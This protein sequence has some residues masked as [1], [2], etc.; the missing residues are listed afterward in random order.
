MVSIIPRS[1]N[2]QRQLLECGRSGG[3]F[4]H[5][6]LALAAQ[7]GILFGLC[8]LMLLNFISVCLA[9]Q[10]R[11]MNPFSM[12]GQRL[13]LRLSH[14]PMLRTCLWVHP[15]CILRCWVSHLRLLHLRWAK[16]A[17][18]LW[19]P[20]MEGSWVLRMVLVRSTLSHALAWC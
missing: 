18:P 15:D 4:D 10:K 2:Q 14:F 8:A 7:Y 1:S 11:A 16:G 6:I 19:S 3:P 13:S 12:R 5:W 20:P 9:V 17:A